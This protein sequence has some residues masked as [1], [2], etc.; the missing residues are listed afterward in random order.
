MMGSQCIEHANN[1]TKS[2][3]KPIVVFERLVTLVIVTITIHN[4]IHLS[5]RHVHGRDWG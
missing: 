2:L 4:V 3:S 1:S 5:H